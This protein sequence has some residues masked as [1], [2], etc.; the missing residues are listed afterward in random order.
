MIGI[1]GLKIFEEQ[2]LGAIFF[3]PVVFGDLFKRFLGSRLI[4][5]EE[6]TG[7]H[8]FITTDVTIV[9]QVQHVKCRVDTLRELP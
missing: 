6:L 5:T 8:P 2:L 1:V 4:D 7:F 9:I 3:E